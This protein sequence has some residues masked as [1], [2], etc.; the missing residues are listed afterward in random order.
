MGG[1]HREGNSIMARIKRRP[2]WEHP[3]PKVDPFSKLPPEM[4][5]YL[6]NF[7]K[8][9]E[10]LGWMR[11]CKRWKE[12][13]KHPAMGTFWRRASV[14]A[15][16]P[17]YCVRNLMPE[18]NAVDEVFHQARYY[19]DHIARIR[20][21]TKLLRGIHPFESTS[22][23]EYAGDGYFV[24]TV[25][26]Q[27]LEEE[28]TVIG[29]LCPHRRTIQKVASF[30]GKYGEVTYASVC[31]GHII[32]QTSE[33]YWFRYNLKD[34][35]FSRLFERLLK[36]EM[37]DSVG[38]CRHCMFILVAN[39]ESIMHGYNWTLRF[40]KIEEDKVV[41]SKHSPKIPSKITQYIPRPVKAHILS[42]DNCKSHRL[43]IQGGTGACVFEVTHNREED[44]IEIS[45][46]PVATLNPFYDSDIAVMVVT[47]TSEMVMSLD[48][49]FV[50]LLTS[51]VYPHASG[52]CLH[53]FDV[54]TYE[55]TLSVKIKWAEGFNDC[56]L[57]AVSQLYAV[58][59]VGHTNG[60]VNIVHCRSGNVVSSLSP[61]AKGLPPVIPMA[62]LMQ[63][64]M[65]GAYGE[66]C[67]VNIKGKLNIAILFR[68]GVGNIEGVFYDPFP[69]SLA[70]LEDSNRAES[71]VDSG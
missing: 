15:G 25:D 62:K 59:A 66:E 69:P 34:G 57:L 39:S 26:Y 17:D 63:V 2:Q 11:V 16:V 29:E 38:H 40:F 13:L 36:K 60:L 3:G 24:K 44:K 14:H 35:S 42:D 46:K 51:I 32:W 19:T 53:F 4:I 22:K 33:G 43:V 9:R 23:C 50:G 70:L 61:M 1:R 45:S 71:D 5:Q 6:T 54:N 21:E 20:P 18:C 10:V 56:R 7:V 52:L 49:T 65:Q 28:E 48:G 68:K 31:V 55:R 58:V 67:L 64:H 37:G 27:S 30:T 41:E 8:V 12:V 47:T